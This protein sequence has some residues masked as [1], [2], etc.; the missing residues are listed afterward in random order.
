MYVL[1]DDHLNLVMYLCMH[2]HNMFSI[3]ALLI[4]YS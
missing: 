2:A 1:L 3:Q 4:F